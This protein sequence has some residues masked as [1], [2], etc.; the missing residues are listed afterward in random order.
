MGDLSIKFKKIVD[1]VNSEGSIS[2][3]FCHG[4]DYWVKLKLV[5][6][7]EFIF[8]RVEFNDLVDF[9]TN[10]TN[11]YGLMNNSPGSDLFISKD[12]KLS[13]LPKL[14]FDYTKIQSG[15]K[16]FKDFPSDCTVEFKDWVELNNSQKRR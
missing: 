9:I 4:D 14:A 13:S 7:K 1:I 11:L 10:I 16:M 8:F 12:N 5:S 2:E 3:L 6:F 15:K